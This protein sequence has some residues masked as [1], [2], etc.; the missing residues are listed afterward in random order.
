M[1]RDVEEQSFRGAGDCA[2]AE[3][4]VQRSRY[5]VA[6]V[7]RCRGAESEVLRGAEVLSRCRGGSAEVIVKLIAQLIVQVQRSRCR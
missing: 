6:E 4:Q 5:I 3:V 2:G 1:C 7:P